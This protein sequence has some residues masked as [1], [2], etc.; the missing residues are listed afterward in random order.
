M[1]S[2]EIYTTTK[3]QNKLNLLFPTNSFPT[4]IAPLA[5]LLV[6]FVITSIASSCR[7]KLKLTTL[8]KPLHQYFFPLIVKDYVVTFCLYLTG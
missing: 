1:I 5:T 8:Q 4:T 6:P 2:K 3:V 7:D